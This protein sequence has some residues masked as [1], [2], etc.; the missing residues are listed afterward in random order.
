MCGISVLFHK[1][2]LN[3]QL[4]YDFISSLRSINHR[5]PDDEGVVLINTNTGDYKIIKTEFTHSLVNDTFSIESVNVNEF[6]L[7]L[8]HRRLSIIDLSVAGHQPMKGKDGSWITFNGEI[9]NYI[10]LRE[11]LKQLG[12]VFITNSDT[13]VVL[14]AY[15]VWGQNCLNKFNGMWTICI[16]DSQKKHLFLSND[17]FG[18]KPL[19][20]YE[21][22]EFFILSS[23][24]KQFLKFSAV[25]KELNQEHITDFVK[26]GFIDVDT[27]TI[28]QTITRF[29]CSH[30]ALIN[31][32]TN[33]KI[34][35]E[36]KSYYNLIKHIKPISEHN[37]I[38]RFREIL[39]S[40]VTLRMRADVNF[41][42][43]LSGGIDSSAVLY[44]ARD[45]MKEQEKQHELLGFSA[46]FPG[47]P[48]DESE[49]VKIVENDL[50]CKTHYSLAMEEFNFDSFEKHIY[51]QDEPLQGTTYFAQWSIYKK[52]SECGIKILFNGQGADEV[53]AGYHHYFYR[54]CRQLLLKGNVPEYL[55]LVKSYAE[56]K[57]VSKKQIH[58]IVF[59]E[60]KL[61]LKLKAGIAKFDHVLLKYWNK[62]DTLDEL[63]IKDFDTFQLPLYLRADDRD[64]MAFG[65]ES[66]HP[67]M[68]YRL[69]EFGY[70]LPNN[71]LI[72]NGWQKYLIRKAMHEMPEAVRYRKDKKGFVTPQ[73]IW[74]ARFKNEFEDYLKYNKKVL[75]TEKPSN[76]PFLNYAL[77]TWFKVNNF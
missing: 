73:N 74:L 71:L 30:F 29:K 34:A 5:G 53:F 13:E 21:K 66:R 43:A 40:S 45:I 65:V 47:Y 1:T 33:F 76:Q 31:L 69:V 19:Y 23:E 63:L 37:A 55:S 77:G 22:E 18:V 16:W 42:F 52:A 60:L 17:R 3:Q 56:I 8:G 54:Y 11:E 36:Q 70:S 41:G 24:I 7:A 32:A 6:N 57:N 2:N 38:L 26:F 68:D 46:I 10:E 12:S 20:Y 9:F 44:T 4:Y 35:N 61:V 25:K 27:S 48:E 62:I 51:H 72:K 50:P 15:R 14:E 49:F 67:F 28:Y 59:N 39:K 58:K 75:G 64:S